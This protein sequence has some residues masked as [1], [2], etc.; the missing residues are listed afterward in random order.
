M[1]TY[2]V[3]PISGGI[4]IFN[5]SGESVAH[6]Q[7]NNAALLLDEIELVEDRWCSM[8]T[9]NIG[10]YAPFHNERENISYVLEFFCM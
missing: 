2:A 9:E 3:P 10:W 5:P 1:Y 6:L 8:T 7:G 4:E